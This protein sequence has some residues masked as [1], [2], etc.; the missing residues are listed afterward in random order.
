MR[1]RLRN[2]AVF[3]RENLGPLFLLLTV[4]VGAALR[5]YGLNWDR[6]N[7]FHPDERMIMMVVK[8]ELSLPR[9]I[10]WGRLLTPESPL[11]PRFFSYGSLPLYLLKMVTNFLSL[12]W[13]AFSEYKYMCL[14]GRAISALFDLGTMLLVYFL[15]RKLYGKR[16]GNLAA[17]LVAFC[18][19]HIQAAHFYAVDSLLAF[20]VF[21]T[22]VLAV[23][24]SRRGSLGKGALAGVFCGFAL[25]TKVSALPLLLTMALAWGIWVLK[26]ETKNP[27]AFEHGG[28][29]ALAQEKLSFRTIKGRVGRWYGRPGGAL[30]GRRAIAGLMGMLTS[31][32]LAGLV[33]AISEPY[34]L[35]DW[36]LFLAHIQR[37][38]AMVRGISDMPYT[39]QYI[40][41]LPYIYHIRQAILFSMGPFLGMAAFGGL[42]FLLGRVVF[43]KGGREEAVILSWVLVY[44]GITGSFQVK[45]LRYLL[46]ISP[47]LCIMAA[48][49]LFALKDWLDARFGAVRLSYLLPVSV[50]LASFLYSL[51]FMHIYR[52]EHPWLRASA[53]VYRNVPRGSRLS[54]EHWDDALPVGIRLDGE[55]RSNGEYISQ[56]LNLY[57]EDE[58]AKVEWMVDRIFTSD[59]II[60]ASN[61]LYGSIPR[62]PVRYPLT[63]RYYELLFGERLGFELVSFAA[64]Y[65]QLFGVT[66]MDD[67]F[68]DPRLPIPA[69]L[70]YYKPSPVTINLGRADES[71]TVYDHPQALIFK[72]TE[73]L[74]R[75]ELYELLRGDLWLEGNEG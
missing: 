40:N 18:V 21:G 9:P 11:N 44:F 56:T 62:L 64:S 57:E 69:P 20:F 58:P 43:G 24:V 55:Q 26:R 31:F 51:A 35:I 72:K 47:F 52:E 6:G 53:W 16:V 33:F 68:R 34:A 45:F 41:T 29:Q 66:F 50:A 74:S 25:A 60:L 19:L 2:S 67:T 38:S 15:G 37:E 13:R 75:W 17:L 14:V 46:P 22:V 8:G 70:A 39:R 12:R 65:P 71:F 63:S 3:P 4:A 42:L 7:L 54:I 27:P 30:A 32:L 5:L 1:G 23:E 10:D 49:A 48:Q 36:E 28:A 59:Y 73:V 61:R